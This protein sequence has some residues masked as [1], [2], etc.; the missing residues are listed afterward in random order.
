MR[1]R[2]WA[3]QPWRGEEGFLEEVMSKVDL[4]DE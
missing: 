4:K 2:L 1:E 3:C